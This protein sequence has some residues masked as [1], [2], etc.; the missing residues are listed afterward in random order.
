MGIFRMVVTLKFWEGYQMQ[1]M[2]SMLAL[3][4]C[5]LHTVSEE[6]EINKILPKHHM[7]D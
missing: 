1:I 2:A 4:A 7:L 6:A 3:I 5:V